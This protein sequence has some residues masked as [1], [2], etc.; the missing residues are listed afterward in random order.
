LEDIVGPTGINGKHAR[1]SIEMSRRPKVILDPK[2]KDKVHVE[3]KL[4]AYSGV[5]KKLTNEEVDNQF[6]T[7]FDSKRKG[8]KKRF[9]SLKTGFR[10]LIYWLDERG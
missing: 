10:R 8:P 4:A 2:D 6:N 3:A 7:S 5:Y 9:P 1:I